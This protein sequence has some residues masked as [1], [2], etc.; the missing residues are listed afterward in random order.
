MPTHNVEYGLVKL[1][2]SRW[3]SV[4]FCDR[5]SDAFF[6]ITVA[7]LPASDRIVT[8]TDARKDDSASTD[9][10]ISPDM[11]LQRREVQPDN[12]GDNDQDA[13]ETK[14]V[15]RFSEQ[16]NPEERGADRSD[17]GPYRIARA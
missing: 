6:N 10:D 13:G 1:I 9:P 5:I 14:G 12:S 15:L 7:P 8:D 3:V 17:A 4:T 11:S 2:C 16:D